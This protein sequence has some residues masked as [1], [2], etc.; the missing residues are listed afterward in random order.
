MR[1]AHPRGGSG[2][3]S[4]PGPEDSIITRVICSVKLLNKV[5]IRFAWADVL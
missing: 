4:N 5:E 2:G 3:T 1:N